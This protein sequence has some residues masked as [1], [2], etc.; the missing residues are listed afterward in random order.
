MEQMLMGVITQIVNEC[1]SLRKPKT[2]REKKPKAVTVEE[3]I[4]DKP[5]IIKYPKIKPI[6]CSVCHCEYVGTYKHI[7]DNIF[8][9]RYD[10]GIYCP[11]CGN[12]NKVEFEEDSDDE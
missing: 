3:E 7:K 5:H 1:K 2:K 11:I 4:L 12:F 9:S 10:R 8:G 6:K